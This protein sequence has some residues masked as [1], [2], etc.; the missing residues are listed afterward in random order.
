MFTTSPA[1]PIWH[2]WRQMPR[3][4]PKDKYIHRHRNEFSGKLGKAVVSALPI[5]ILNDEILAFDPAQRLQFLAKLLNRLQRQVSQQADPFR[6]LILLRERKTRPRRSS[7]GENA[8][9]FPPLQAIPL[10]AD[11]RRYR[12]IC[13][14]D[15]RP[16]AAPT[17]A[18]IP[19]GNHVRGRCFKAF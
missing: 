13:T 17:G 4:F 15:N 1:A 19:A 2:A 11:I 6:R 9:K 3:G 14:V 5:S 16:D 10:R 8:Q 18:D 7:T 12:R